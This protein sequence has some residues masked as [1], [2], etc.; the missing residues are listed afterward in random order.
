MLQQ[1][2]NNIGLT[3]DGRYNDGIS[4]NV[5]HYFAIFIQYFFFPTNVIWGGR[6]WGN[7]TFD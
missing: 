6:K 5:N 2:S 3:S 4:Y 7:K 1:P